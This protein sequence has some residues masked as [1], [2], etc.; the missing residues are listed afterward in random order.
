MSIL[1]PS[2]LASSV[3]STEWLCLPL[4][5]SIHP[6]S[7]LLSSLLLSS[8]IGIEI[9]MLADEMRLQ[10]RLHLMLQQPVSSAMAKAT[11]MLANEMQLRLLY[12]LMSEPPVPPGF[13]KVTAM[14]AHEMWS[15][16]P[17][18]S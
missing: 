11:A 12:Q 3:I 16:H 6:V 10:F 1:R 13:V 5:Y 18:C 9:P 4:R 8:S 2:R 7:K 15:R 17:N 14:L